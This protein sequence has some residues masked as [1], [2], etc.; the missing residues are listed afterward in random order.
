M[1]RPHAT[2]GFARCQGEKYSSARRGVSLIEVII[3]LTVLALLLAVAVPRLQ[4]ARDRAQEALVSSD[5]E[6]LSFLQEQH[7]AL[8]ARQ[9]ARDL[10]VLR[11]TPSVGVDITVVAADERGWSARGTH[12]KEPEL[13]CAV[14]HSDVRSG[15]PWPAKVAGEINCGRRQRSSS[16]GVGD[17]AMIR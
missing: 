7:L 13:H 9:Y 15:H 3:A 6:R 16:G 10:S 14:F 4:R 17:G 12:A 5:L 8:G 11:F 1:A 2:F